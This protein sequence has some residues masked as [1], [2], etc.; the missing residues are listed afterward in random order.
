MID[1]YVRKQDYQR[2][3]T[4]IKCTPDDAIDELNSRFKEHGVGY[5]YESGELIRVDSQFLHAEAVK[6]TLNLLGSVDI[7]SQPYDRTDKL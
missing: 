2:F 4:N 3:V 6:P 7:L 5:Q 1:L